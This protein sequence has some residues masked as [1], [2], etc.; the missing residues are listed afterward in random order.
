MKNK[1][2]LIILGVIAAGL[3]AT[4]GFA[5]APGEHE[6]TKCDTATA[7]AT[8]SV[9]GHSVDV[10]GARVKDIPGAQ[11]VQTAT[12]QV[13][14]TATATDQTVTVTTTAPPLPQGNV[15]PD[16]TFSWDNQADNYGPGTQFDRVARGLTGTNPAGQSVANAGVCPITPYINASP[17][18]VYTR[19][20]D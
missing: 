10:D 1:L 13:C 14:V 5:A 6:V 20:V 7:T 8:A 18:S 16:Y 9:P 19:T 15:L 3:V 2:V 11:D 12:K 4:L 17:A